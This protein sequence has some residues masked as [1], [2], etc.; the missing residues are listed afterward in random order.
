MV[1]ILECFEIL[2]NFCG[3]DDWFRKPH[4]RPFWK[5]WLGSRPTCVDKSITYYGGRF[6]DCQSPTF[7]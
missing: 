3:V 2:A 6:G 7:A 4:M 1:E 5:V